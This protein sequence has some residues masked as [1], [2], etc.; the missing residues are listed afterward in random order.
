[1]P[2]FLMISVAIFHVMLGADGTGAVKDER[3]KQRF[4]G[5]L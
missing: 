4:L 2:L 1:M 3:G 5:P